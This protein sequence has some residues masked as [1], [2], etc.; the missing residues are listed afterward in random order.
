MEI[1]SMEIKAKAGLRD[2]VAMMRPDYWIKH[3]FIVPGI[4]FALLLGADDARFVPTTVILGFVIAALLSSANYIINEWLDASFDAHHPSK[5]QRAAVTKQVS[6]AIVTALYLLLAGSGLVLATL[7]STSIAVV[8]LLFLLS[9][10]S[11]N[12]API[13][14]KDKAYLD[15]AMEAINNPIRL[16]LGWLLVDLTTLPPASLIF[17]YW[18]GGGFLMSV[19]RL[20]EYRSISRSS[21]LDKLHLY[22]ASFRHY[23][24]SALLIQS[25]LYAQLSS[26][27]LAVFLIKYRIEY[28]LSLPLFALLFAV[29]FWIGLQPHSSA[30]APE[31]LMSEKTLVGLVFALVLLL[32]VLTVFDIPALAIF[33]KPFIL[34]T[35]QIP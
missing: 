4:V 32:T 14:T 24:E 11:Y 5:S 13:R 28:L 35:T 6:P 27:F 33:S 19:K 21:G 7:L 10:L 2:Y 16:T 12:I 9:G 30:Q 1:E 23:S 17:V 31:R 15:V 3:I 26:F 22:R 18:A 34:H 29:Y 8:A 20:A 25:F